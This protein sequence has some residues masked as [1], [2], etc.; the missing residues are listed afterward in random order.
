MS[1]ASNTIA[2]LTSPPRKSAEVPARPVLARARVT[3]PPSS[4]VDSLEVVVPNFSQDHPYTINAEQWYQGQTLPVV[5]DECVVMFDDDGDIWVSSWAHDQLNSPIGPAGG[6]LSGTY[7][8]PV[9]GPGKV[10]D[11]KVAAGAAIAESKLSLASDAAS[12]TPSRR[13]LGP[14]ALQAASGNHKHPLA[15]VSGTALGA[16]NVPYWDGSAWVAASQAQLESE[17]AAPFE[18]TITGDGATTLFTINH[19]LGTRNVEVV[20]RENVAPWE[21]V[22]VRVRAPSTSTVTVEVSPALA[23]G[24]VYNVMVARAFGGATVP[25]SSPAAHNT[26]HSVGGSDALERDAVDARVIRDRSIY[27]PYATLGSNA[28]SIAFTT[29]G[30]FTRVTGN[31][32]SGQAPPWG[33]TIPAR[34]TD[35]MWEFWGTVFIQANSA[36]W[37]KTDVRLIRTNLLGGT[38]QEQIGPRARAMCHLNVAGQEIEHSVQITPRPLTIVAGAAVFIE[39]EVGGVGAFGGNFQPPHNPISGNHYPIIG[40]RKLDRA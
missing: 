40:G 5:G 12:G 34:A 24:V 27:A 37:T 6:D 11:A 8:N 15:D 19:N 3:K 13:T 29:G 26:T 7:P 1:P 28:G 33:L 21:F 17:L 16:N 32:V 20:V 25:V 30:G 31:I 35:E 23:V 14:G 38:I 9:I 36:N 4:S 39:M 18:T 10:T 2:D 22:Q